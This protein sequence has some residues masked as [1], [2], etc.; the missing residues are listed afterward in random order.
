MTKESIRERLK[1][2]T[3]NVAGLNALV[4]GMG[5]SGN[6]AAGLLHRE[7]AHLWIYDADRA[8]ESAIRHEWEPRGARCLFGEL[9]PIQE[10]DFCVISPGV[11]PFGAFFDWL[12][13][14]G[15]PLLGEMELASRFLERF[16]LAVTGTNG[17]TTVVNMIAHIFKTRGRSVFLAGNV[18]APVAALAM[19]EDRGNDA[20]LVLE[21]SSFQAETF[22]QFKADV[23]VIT[24]LAPDHLDR[25]ESAEQYYETKFRMV[26]NQRP[27][28]ALWMGLGVEGNCPDWVSSRRRAFSIDELRPDG[29][30]YQDGTVI[31]RGDSREERLSGRSLANQLPQ[32]ILNSLASIGAC[33]SAG[34]HPAEALEALESFQSL[35]HRL[36]YVTEKRGIRCYNDSKATNI[37][38]LET[39]LRSLPAPIRLIAGGRAKGD[40]PS[41]LAALIQEKVCAVHLIGEAAETFARVWGSLTH[42]EMEPSLEAAVEHGLRDGNPGESFVLSPGCS[43]FDMFANYQER[44]DCFKKSVLEFEA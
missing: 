4:L 7:G 26:K 34:I 5:T 28:E 20:P 8:K 15:I 30:F 40:S 19:E 33:L 44:G 10:L 12:R 3:P 16:T 1:R 25:Y 24:N 22:D 17:K 41:S 23:G 13:A 31:V 21:V 6:A 2:P 11:P 43:S 42:A 35:P 14:T 36:E 32:F 37:H 38:A 29:V 27:N 9:R 39:A 18:G